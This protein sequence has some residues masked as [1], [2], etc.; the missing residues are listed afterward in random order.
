MSKARGFI[1]VVIIA[2]ALLPGLAPP[3]ASAESFTAI[4]SQPPNWK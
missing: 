4:N 1:N 2:T 3:H